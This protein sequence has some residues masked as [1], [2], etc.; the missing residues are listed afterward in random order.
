MADGF[1][2]HASVAVAADDDLGRERLCRYGARPPLALDRLRRLPDG[3]VAYR[4]KAQRDGRAKL[5]R[6]GPQTRASTPETCRLDV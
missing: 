1:N 6:A 4:I 5:W 2:L 3:R